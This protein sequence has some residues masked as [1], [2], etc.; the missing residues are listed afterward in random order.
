MMLYDNGTLRFI[1]CCRLYEPGRY[2]GGYRPKMCVT[3]VLGGFGGKPWFYTFW[4]F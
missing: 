4:G 2:F 1:I 3:K